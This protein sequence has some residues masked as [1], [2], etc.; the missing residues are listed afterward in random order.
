MIIVVYNSSTARAQDVI[1]IIL[2]TMECSL[3]KRIQIILLSAARQ[4][5]RGLE[6][7]NTTPKNDMEQSVALAA[8]QKSDCNLDRT[9][10]VVCCRLFDNSFN[11]DHAL[12]RTIMMLAWD[13]KHVSM[14]QHLELSVSRLTA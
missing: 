11:W 13:K 3:S 1:R 10:D 8:V 7:A 4:D 12:V 14:R 9:I 5:V 2:L 6:R